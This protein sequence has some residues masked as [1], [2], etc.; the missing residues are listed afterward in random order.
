MRR[1]LVAAA[2]AAAAAGF[3]ALFFFLGRSP[4]GPVEPAW[5]RTTCA[6]CRMHLSEPAFAAQLQ[7]ESGELL[8]FDDPGCLFAWRG[9]HDD[10]GRVYFRLAADA[11]WREER[12]VAFLPVGESPMGWGLAAVAAGTPGAIPAAEAAR[13][14]LE[15]SRS[16]DEPAHGGASR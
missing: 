14:V 3:V 12:E 2:L 11:G 5:D 9:E 7:S 13:R 16:A 15:R 4:S 1:T 6:H 8:F 10:P